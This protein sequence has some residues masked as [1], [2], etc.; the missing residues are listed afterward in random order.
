MI[1]EHVIDIEEIGVGV[2]SEETVEIVV[3][4][5]M[6]LA[7]A[8][9]AKEYAMV[10]LRRESV[11]DKVNVVELNNF[12]GKL[13]TTNITSR[14]L[15]VKEE[16]YSFAS[17]SEVYFSSVGSPVLFLFLHNALPPTLLQKCER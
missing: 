9:G 17:G 12:N 16:F 11:A 6:E 1:F 7:V 13:T 8:V 4:F 10:Y 2:F 3:E 14:I 15:F 5:G